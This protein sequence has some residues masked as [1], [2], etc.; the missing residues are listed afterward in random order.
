MTKRPIFLWMILII[1]LRSGRLSNGS[2][3]GNLCQSNPILNFN[4]E[5]KSLFFEKARTEKEA[6]K[7]F[8][9]LAEE[10]MLKWSLV[11]STLMLLKSLRN[12]KKTARSTGN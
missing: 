7:T 8:G 9:L 2:A 5:G 11:S 4:D 3:V 10:K 6:V 1:W 12:L